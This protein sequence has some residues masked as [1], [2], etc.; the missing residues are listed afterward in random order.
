MKK[1]TALLIAIF[2][3][4]VMLP[5]IDFSLSAGGGG[6]LGYTFTRYTLEGG[7]VTS[8]QSMDRLNYGGWLFFDATYGEFTVMFQGGNNSYAEKMDYGVTSLANST[9]RGYEASL[10][11][12][13]L[14]K[15][16]FRINEKISWFPLLGIEYQIA[17]VEKRQPE[18]GVT[19]NRTKS[20][21]PEDNDKNGKPYP[22]SAW[23]SWW[24]DIG[25]GL[26][27]NITGLLFLRSELIFG[28][29]LRTDYE[30]GAL[31]VVQN[32][33][34]N[35]KDPKLTGLTGG[36]ALRIAAGWRFS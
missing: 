10:G 35:V 5:A 23:N 12:S 20:Y 11:F 8:T 4:A 21:F 26:D 19:Y 1:Y 24:I 28:F 25:A 14:G 27:Y 36:P 6:L 3:P 34:V 17:L 31:E 29:R 9:G 18:D 2:A 7:D 22:L 15:Y 30:K 13:L 16:P 33:P 32:P